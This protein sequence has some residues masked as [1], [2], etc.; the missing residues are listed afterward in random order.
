MSLR[1]TDNTIYIFRV[2]LK[3]HNL[4][5]TLLKYFYYLVNI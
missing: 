3:K 5:F 2:R 1:F 4:S